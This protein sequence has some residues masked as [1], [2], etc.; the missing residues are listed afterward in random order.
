MHIGDLRGGIAGR[1]HFH[2][3]GKRCQHTQNGENYGADDVEQQVDNCGAFCVAAGADGSQ[4][5]CNT[6]A[7]IL[8]EQDINCAAQIDNAALGQSLQNTDRSRRGLNDSRKD[9]TG[10]NAENRVGETGHQRHKRFGITQRHHRTAHHFHADKQNAEAGNDLSPMACLRIFEKHHKRH[11]DESKQRRQFT[12]IER[13]QLAGNRG[14]DIGAHDDPNGLAQRH[15][16]GVDKAYHHN[17]RGRGGLNDS[18]DDSADG[19]T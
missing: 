11:T 4:N 9:S 10:Q 19:H 3:A 18:G 5:S 1:Q 6:S 13:N 17:R 2:P 12:Y 15:H 8:A 16:A 14:A 7:D